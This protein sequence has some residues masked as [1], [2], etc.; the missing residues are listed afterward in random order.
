MDRQTFA[1]LESLLWLKRLYNELKVWERLLFDYITIIFMFCNVSCVWSWFSDEECS[2]Y[3][4]NL[5]TFSLIFTFHLSSTYHQNIHYWGVKKLD[6][7]KYS[8]GRFW[9]SFFDV[10]W[11][12]GNVSKPFLLVN[13]GLFFGKSCTFSCVQ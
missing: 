3:C 5:S 13:S 11:N 10:Y 9:K 6:N 7:K 4:P 8:E 2:H 1:I 12:L